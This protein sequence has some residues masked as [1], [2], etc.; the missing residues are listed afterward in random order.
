MQSISSAAELERV[1]DHIYRAEQAALRDPPALGRVQRLLRLL[2]LDE[3]ARYRRA[4]RFPIN[5]DFAQPTP[6]FIDAGGVRCAMAHLLEIGGESALVSAIAR[7]RNNAWVREL[8][9]EPR[10]LRWLAAAGLSVDEAAAIQ[11]AY[12]SQVTDCICGGDFSFVGYPVPALGVLEGV[13]QA[14][15]M[16]RVERT[17]GDPLGIT[18]GT[19]VALDSA[20]AEGTRVLA[21]IDTSSPPSG[22]AAIALDAEGIYECQ[23]QGVASAPELGAADFAQAVLASDC[24]AAL[25]DL[26]SAWSEEPD[27]NGDGGGGGDGGGCDAAS[28]ESLSIGI[29]LAVVTALSARRRG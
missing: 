10:L 22:Y 25:E 5:R 20:F 21:P 4:G 16:A 15:G 7:E 9:D 12:C 19:D 14:N 8:A 13:V 23:S 17:Y 2:L 18:V 29:L 3:L 28:S 24:A 6:Y 1:T 11:P 26:D 27:C